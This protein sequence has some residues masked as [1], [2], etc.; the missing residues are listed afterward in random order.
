M[1]DAHFHLVVNHL[2][3]I[4]PGIAALV[5]LGGFIFKSE[6]VKRTAYVLF[7]IGS[8]STLLALN[9]GEGAEE[10]VEH[11]PGVSH[12]LIH[13]HEE[14]AETFAI[15]SHILGLLSIVGLWANYKRKKFSN[16][17]GI[18]VLLLGIVL[19]YFGRITGTTGGEIMHPEIR[20]DFTPGAEEQHQGEYDAD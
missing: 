10:V 19:I 7:V 17:I 3:I 15:I 18:I 20:A 1:N 4:I 14:A 6:I 2:P 13:E 9:S 12:D 8:I 5:L 16:I 11:L